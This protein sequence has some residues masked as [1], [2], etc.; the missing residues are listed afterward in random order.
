M[1]AKTEERQQQLVLL[2]QQ[3]QQQLAVDGTSSFA[4]LCDFL[5]VKMLPNADAS[6]DVQPDFENEKP[7]GDPL[8]RRAS[9][10][11]SKTSDPRKLLSSI[12][13]KNGKGIPEEP[14]PEIPIS[15][16]SIR[17]QSFAVIRDLAA[18]K[19]EP[20]KV[21][22]GVEADDTE[23][24]KRSGKQAAAKK[25]ENSAAKTGKATT[26]TGQGNAKGG[27]KSTVPAVEP[28]KLSLE[29]EALQLLPKDENGRLTSCHES[30]I[31]T[32]LA[33][34]EARSILHVGAH[35][36]SF[37]V[38]LLCTRS[39][40]LGDMDVAEGRV[41]VVHKTL[42]AVKKQFLAYRAKRPQS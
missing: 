6:L 33:Y 26:G 14:V 40:L 32:N 23:G 20:V 39:L 24:G 5:G 16:I 10:L 22:A 29:D 28:P 13:T 4:A 9:S 42:H 8:S 35:P 19:F 12:S 31:S 27:M 34:P 38:S 2:S 41:Q 21:E 18:T 15:I 1:A 7:A 17:N 36:V 25:S 11:K 30:V 37:T 3:L